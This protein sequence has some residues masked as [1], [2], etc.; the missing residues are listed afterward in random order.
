MI[1]LKSKNDIILLENQILIEKNMWDYKGIKCQAYKIAWYKEGGLTNQEINW[2]DDQRR[3]EDGEYGG[4]RTHIGW[5]ERTPN[6]LV[7]MVDY[8]GF[9]H[10]HAEYHCQVCEIKNT[11]FLVKID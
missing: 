10:T 6:K 5:S 9:N 2:I 11:L 1:L 8:G 4:Y 7:Y 3:E